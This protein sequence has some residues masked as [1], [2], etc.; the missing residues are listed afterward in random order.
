MNYE[1][2]DNTK[3]CQG[4]TRISSRL[5]VSLLVSQ[6]VSQ[7]AKSCLCDWTADNKDCNNCD[8]CD[9]HLPPQLTIHIT[10]GSPGVSMSP[11]TISQQI[12]NNSI[13]SCGRDRNDNFLFNYFR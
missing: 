6:S 10:G 8:T 1:R 3:F 12:G 2:E 13:A 9:P 4:E 7:S 11:C 5:S